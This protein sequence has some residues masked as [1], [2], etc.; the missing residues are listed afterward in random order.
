MNFDDYRTRFTNG[1]CEALLWADTTVW[2]DESGENDYP[3]ESYWWQSPGASW[4]VEAFD[5]D[6]RAR[7]TEDCDAFVESEWLLLLAYE[8]APEY[9]GHD[10]LLSRNHHGTGFWDRGAGV[11]GDL[12][13]KASEPYGTTNAYCYPPG[14]HDDDLAH[15]LEG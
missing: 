4:A 9:A 11:L 2:V 15:L 5:A 13:H 10:F 3:A 12:L 7:I 8:R 1:Y 6:D 14:D